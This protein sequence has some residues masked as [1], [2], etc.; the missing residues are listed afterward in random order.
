MSKKNHYQSTV[1]DHL[2]DE[3]IIAYLDGELSD[4]E[5]ARAGQHL[6]KC[7]SCRGNLKLIQDSVDNFMNQRQEIL[8]PPALPPS[9]PALKI[10]QERLQNY[11]SQTRTASVFSFSR[12]KSKVNFSNFWK[13]FS[14]FNF[15][16]APASLKFGVGALAVFVIVALILNQ[17]V[18]PTVSAAELLKNADEAGK[19]SLSAVSQ[20]VVHQKLQV[21]RSKNNSPVESVNWETWDD[22]S[23]NNFRQAV[24]TDGA[25]RLIIDR[26]ES[27]V[28]VPFIFENERPQVL[29][30]LAQILQFNRMNPNDPLAAAS[31]KNW[32]DSLAEKNETVSKADSQDG[33]ESYQLNVKPAGEIGSNQISA[34]DY[35]VRASDWTPLKLRL[36][37]KTND[38]T[39]NF[40]ITRQT[41]EVI[42]FNQLSPEI[43]PPTEM[44]KLPNA[45]TSPKE[46]SSL[47]P[48]PETELAVKTNSN[49]AA[50]VK[51]ENATNR[52]PA[53]AELEVEV[54][55]L[56]SQVR[57]DMGEQIEVKRTPDGFLV[58][59]G[60]IETAG[61]KTEILNALDS[62]ADNAS[63]KIEIYTIAEAVA[64]RK[65]ESK[66]KDSPVTNVESVEVENLSLAAEPQLR[67]Y[68]GQSGNSD[69]KI[70]SYA[71]SRVAQSRQA[72]QH[73]G[74]LKKIANQFKPEELKTL[75]PEAREK[76][77]ALIRSHARAFAEQN[78]ALRR[79]LKPVFFAGAGEG[80]GR[81]ASV[82]SNAEL[83]NA[84]RQLYETGA[85]NDSVIL[86]AFAASGNGGVSAIGAAQFWQALKNAEAMAR[87]IQGVR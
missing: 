78:S 57:A 36:E 43:F 5:K 27:S 35:I 25:R 82:S 73:L 65:Q 66:T 12:L 24:E 51:T 85:A 63:V 44:A 10:F 45:T 9:E 15:F 70:R 17:S 16:N 18:V 19:N 60:I 37:I 32:R 42:A 77:L 23:R 14:S 34:A 4:E 55:N 46:S 87:S 50:V 29:T 69:E 56:L 22:T 62:V 74:A 58:I 49:S 83:I 20:P 3:T 41:S 28:K 33:T 52:V 30:E 76:W 81:G 48:S 72:M 75:K 39:I 7:W 68:F 40:E 67:E 26:F 2:E 11:K 79:E 54:L 61:R 13:T 71:A 64:K 59:S 38:E 8:L 1:P 84:I 6:E 80:G 86:S 53:S 47:A 31:F 21:R